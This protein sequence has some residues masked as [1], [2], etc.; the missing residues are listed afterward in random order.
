MKIRAAIP[1]LFLLCVSSGYGLC[2]TSQTPSSQPAA[3]QS[4][5]S[6]SGAADSAIATKIDPVKEADIRQLME[7]GGGSAAINQV[8]DGMQANMK[9]SLVNSLPPGDYRGQL[10]D[11]FF[12]KFRAKANISQLMDIAVRVY[13]KYLTDEDVKGLIQFYSTPIGKKTLGLLPK[14]TVEMQTDGMQWGENLGRESMR[15]VLLEH[16]ELTKALQDS[17]KGAAPHQ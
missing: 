5:A 11:L 6:S 2:Q 14:I 3:G 17:Q 13:D 10:V 4:G 1:C 9:A 15:E 8:M 7:L 16:P 12:E